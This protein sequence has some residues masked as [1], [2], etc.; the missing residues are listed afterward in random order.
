MRSLRDGIAANARVLAETRAES[1]RRVAG[2]SV[3]VLF[4]TL[5][6]FLFPMQPAS[7][8]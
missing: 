7:V 5:F 1:R 6:S 4:V 3:D 2:M 8:R